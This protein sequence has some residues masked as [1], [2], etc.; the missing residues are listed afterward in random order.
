MKNLFLMLCLALIGFNANAQYSWNGTFPPSPTSGDYVNGTGPVYSTNVYTVTNTA[1]DT[2]HV[3]LGPG[4]NNYCYQSVTFQV[5]ITKISGTAGG[6]VTLYGSNE[7]GTG[8]GFVQIATYTVTTVTPQYYSKVVTGNPYTNY[9][10]VL[11]GA[12]NEVL[13]WIGTLLLR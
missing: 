10:T 5:D 3:K 11:Q 2:A 12:G 4:P 6:T 8:I 9:W 7:T 1:T 13:T